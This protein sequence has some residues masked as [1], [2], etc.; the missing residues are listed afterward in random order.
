[1]WLEN[2]LCRIHNELGENWLCQTCKIFPRLRHDYGNFVELGLELSCPEAARLILTSFPHERINESVPG[3]ETPD[4]D[5][6]SMDI[7]LRSRDIILD[8]LKTTPLPAGKALAVV[9]LYSHAV[10]YELDGGNV[11]VLYPDEALSTA[12][13]IAEAGTQ[14]ALITYFQNLEILTPQW[15]SALQ[16]PNESPWQLTHIA[17]A[18]Y[19]IDRY[20][21]QAISDSDLIGRVKLCIISCLITKLLG[22][23][24]LHTAQLYSKEIENNIDNVYTILDSAYTCP[25]M[26]DAKLLGMLLKPE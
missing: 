26:T 22:G 16:H 5:T 7:L 19:F 21:L 18:S 20:W 8:F 23:D 10:Q 3:G 25:A 17:L 15:R 4:Y 24:P 6:A 2:G 14:Q 12:Q 11:A 13:R 9:L 1:M